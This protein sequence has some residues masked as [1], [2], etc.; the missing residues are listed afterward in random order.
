M[1]HIDAT[2]SELIDK[3]TGA[4]KDA[5]IKQ[6]FLPTESQTIL[7]IPRSHQCT[8]DHMVQ[9]YTPKGNFSVNSAYKVAIAVGKYACYV[10][11]RKLNGSTSLENDNMCYVSF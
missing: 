5:L 1:L 10:H 3:T 2:V 4:W 7:S 6:I 9:A 8:H 11:S